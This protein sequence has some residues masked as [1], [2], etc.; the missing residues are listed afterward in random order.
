[1]FAHEPHD[2]HERAGYLR[3]AT[4]TH[5][6]LSDNTSFDIES[7][8]DA[9]LLTQF[10]AINLLYD[11]LVNAS[12]SRGSSL[13]L[14][15]LS[16]FDEWADSTAHPVFN[17]PETITSWGW[18]QLHRRSFPLPAEHDNRCAFPKSVYIDSSNGH[19]HDRAVEAFSAQ[20]NAF[21]TED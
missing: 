21:V 5:P 6:R 16:Y 19:E 7:E 12:Y 15:D 1:M 9:G 18:H 17:I 14:I 2:T 13:L 11:Y 20:E 8:I 10:D 4:F 3:V